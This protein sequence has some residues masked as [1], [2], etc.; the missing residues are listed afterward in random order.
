MAAHVKLGNPAGPINGRCEVLVD[1][2]ESS[3]IVLAAI[4][5]CPLRRALWAQAA[6]GNL[7]TER[8]RHA[9]GRLMRTSLTRCLRRNFPGSAQ[10]LVRGERSTNSI[11]QMTTLNGQGH[12]GCARINLSYDCNDPS[13]YPA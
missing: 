2:G 10:R 5:E 1:A 11:W 8:Q 12:K 9:S 4:T 13:Q 6:K 7:G 3:K